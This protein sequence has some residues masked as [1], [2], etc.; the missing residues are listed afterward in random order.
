MKRIYLLLFSFW[1]VMPAIMYSQIGGSVF[2]V[3]KKEQQKATDA[4]K[5]ASDKKAANQEANDMHNVLMAINE[6]YP[7][8]EYNDDQ[9]EARC[10]KLI[11]DHAKELVESQKK[12]MIA[13]SCIAR[14]TLLEHQAL[15][16]LSAGTKMFCSDEFNSD[17]V[18]YGGLLIELT[19]AIPE[20]ERNTPLTHAYN[21]IV[22]AGVKFGN[23]YKKPFNILGQYIDEV[24]E[25]IRR[26]KENGEEADLD[27]IFAKYVDF[28][29]EQWEEFYFTKASELFVDYIN[30][31]M[32]PEFMATRAK[33]IADEIE[34]LPCK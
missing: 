13:K 23:P 29:D 17:K 25:E 12:V 33:E 2:D 34:T 1:F 21:N 31:F 28:T 27:E 16:I 32:S 8:N 7:M 5:E 20:E 6:Y 19:V 11:G 26:M 15:L 3:A 9:V 14:K 30:Y 24:I 18:Y 10:L 4:G 22:K